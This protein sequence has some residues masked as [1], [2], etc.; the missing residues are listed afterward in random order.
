MRT[1][2]KTISCFICCSVVILL[3]GCTSIDDRWDDFYMNTDD[4]Q[5]NALVCEI[6]E[7]STVTYYI[8]DG[9]GIWVENGTTHL[10]ELEYIPK[11]HGGGC[12]EILECVFSS[13]YTEAGYTVWNHRDDTLIFRANGELSEND[14]AAVFEREGFDV[15]EITDGSVESIVIKKMLI[16]AEEIVSYEQA[17]EACNFVPDEY[18]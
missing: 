9:Y 12:F 16:P 18:S 5:Y 10:I 17:V 6:S 11:R 3:F 4:G 13:Y 8:D 15:N 7:D 2:L 1:F 14:A